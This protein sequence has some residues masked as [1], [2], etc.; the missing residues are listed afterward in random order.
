ML[1]AASTSYRGTIDL[2]AHRRQCQSGVKVGR[3]RVLRQCE[4]R[5]P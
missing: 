1:P 5:D 4:L 2:S 3:N